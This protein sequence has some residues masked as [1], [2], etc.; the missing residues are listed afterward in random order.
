MLTITLNFNHVTMFLHSY[1]SL[2]FIIVFMN[3]S[4]ANSGKFLRSPVS[5]NVIVDTVAVLQCQHTSADGINWRINGS[6]LRDLPEGVSTYRSS[7]GIYI[8]T[9]I[10]LLKYNQTVVECVAL[11]DDFPSERTNPAALMVQG[12]YAIVCQHDV[13]SEEK[14]C[15]S[16][17]S[18]NLEFLELR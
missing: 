17:D 9:I 16:K 5:L 1:L 8:L 6:T 10:A 15:N 14:V 18:H 12:K 3:T 4:I 13:D 11:F 7:D 2:F